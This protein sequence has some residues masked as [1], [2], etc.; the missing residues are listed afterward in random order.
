MQTKEKYQDDVLEVL[1][2]ATR[3]H[4]TSFEGAYCFDSIIDNG[5]TH[6]AIKVSK[7]I[8]NVDVHARHELRKICPI[9]RCSPLLIGERTRKG[10][11]QDG[12]VHTRGDVPVINLETLRQ[13]LEEQ[14]HPYLKAKKGGVVIVLDGE[15]LKEAREAKNYSRGD[16]AEEIG[17]SRRAIYEYERGKMNPTIEIALHLEELL[18]ISLVKPIDLFEIGQGEIESPTKTEAIRSRLVQRTL[19][20]LS[21]LGISPTLTKETPF[22]LLAAIRRNVILSC[23]QRCIE[24]LDEPRLLFLA[25]LADV[26]KEH[27]VIIASDLSEVESIKGIP[28]IYLREL[29]EIKNPTEVVKLIQQRRGA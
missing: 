3:E 6:I 12:V 13:M 11:I 17:L 26:L 20:A 14:T 1:D 21:R 2:S 22:D 9:L 10:P 19:Q 16:V 15:K 23:L 4:A 25:K 29:S 8:D 18:D 24:Q 5:K 27:P 7:I 28:V